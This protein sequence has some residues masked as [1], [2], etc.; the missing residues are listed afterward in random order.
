MR[1]GTVCM[2][3]DNLSAYKERVV[4]AEQLGFEVIADG[5]TQSVYRDVYVGLAVSAGI[6][7]NADGH[8]RCHTSPRRHRQRDGCC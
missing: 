4:L 5:D 8:Q 3:R 2:W 6:T 1:F 7:E